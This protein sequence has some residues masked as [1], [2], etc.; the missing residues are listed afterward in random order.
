MHREIDDLCTN[1]PSIGRGEERDDPTR[2]FV[3]WCL[4]AAERHHNK[5]YV[6][7]ALLLVYQAGWLST[8][9]TAQL[10][11]KL[12]PKIMRARVNEPTRT[13]GKTQARR[14]W[15]DAREKHGRFRGWRTTD[16]AD[17]LQKYYAGMAEIKRESLERYI[18]EL[19][20]ASSK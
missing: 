3:H 1:V 11:E 7:M 17:H 15:A 4:D 16:Q 10:L 13:G 2:Q 14:A 20:N 12:A 19:R 9:G 18:R 6:H 8:Y 5:G